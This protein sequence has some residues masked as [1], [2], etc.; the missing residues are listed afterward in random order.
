MLLKAVGRSNYFAR[1]VVN[2]KRRK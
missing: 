1:F 2:V